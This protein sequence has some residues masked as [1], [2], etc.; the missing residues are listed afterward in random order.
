[1]I[2]ARYLTAMTCDAVRA[3]LW[4]AMSTVTTGAI[5]ML[6]LRRAKAGVAGRTLELRAARRAVSL[7]A[8]RAVAVVH[9]QVLHTMTIAATI[10]RG[11]KLVWGMTRLASLVRRDRGAFRSGSLSSMTGYAATCS[12]RSGVW[13]VAIRAVLML[14]D[15]KRRQGRCDGL[16]ARHTHLYG[17]PALVRGMARGATLVAMTTLRLVASGAS[18]RRVLSRMPAVAAQAVGVTFRLPSPK[19]H[20]LARVTLNALARRWLELMSPVAAGATMVFCGQLVGCAAG[21]SGGM[22]TDA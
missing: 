16:V 14:W 3:A 1:M 22:A 18:Q 4:L 15:P 8:F 10:G 19:F 12:E 9:S 5:R 20:L 11:P 21:A 7:V 6:T 2:S 17:S 13:C